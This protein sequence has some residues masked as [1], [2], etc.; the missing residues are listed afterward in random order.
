[1]IQYIHKIGV[2][3]GENLKNEIMGQ[4]RHLFIYGYESKERTDFLKSLEDD[5]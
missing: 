1:M 2:F 3:M 4:S 5:L